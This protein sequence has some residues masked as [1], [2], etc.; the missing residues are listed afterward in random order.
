MPHEAYEEARAK[1]LEF[2]AVRHSDVTLASMQ[3]SQCRV[4]AGQQW[5]HRQERTAQFVHGHVP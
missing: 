1:F 3:T 4:V 5:Q 2:D